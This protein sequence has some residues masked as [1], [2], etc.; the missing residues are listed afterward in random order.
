[1]RVPLK[2]LS[3]YV[4]LSLDADE[5][6]ELLTASGTSVEGVE[7]VG[8]EWKG[9]VV[10]RILEVLPHPSADRL[11]VCR[12]DVGGATR[13]IVCGAPN[14]RPGMV[15]PVAL[16][17]NRLPDGRSIGEA[18]IRGV[19]SSGM[20][21]SERELGISDEAAGIMEL[22]GALQP[23]TDLAEALEVEDTVLVLEI[24]P[25]RPDC[26]SMLGVAREVAA[27]TGRRVRRPRFDLP[28][29][30]EPAAS[31]VKVEILEADRCPRYVARLIEGVSI[32]P[33]PWWLRN[34]LRAAGM[35][36]INNVV[37]VTNY[38]MLEL[39]QPLHAFDFHLLRDGHIIVRCKREGERLTTLDGVERELHP[40]DLLI[41]DPGGPVALAGVMGGENTEVNPGTVKVLLESAHFSAPGIMLTSRRHDL[42]SEASYRF[43]RG[44][45]PAGCLFAADRA[46]FLIKETAGGRVRRG[47]VDVVVKPEVLLPRELRLRVGRAARLIGITL[48]APE[49]RGILQ[50]LE[51]EVSTA[52][53]GG[54]S[55]AG[56][57]GEGVPPPP[58]VAGGEGDGE[59]L[60]VKV[61][62]FRPDLER[63]IDLVEELARVYGYQRV[64]ATLPRT[65]NNVGFLTREQVL[66][67]EIA[68]VMVGC[69]LHEA[70]TWA[71]IPFWWMDLLDPE[72]KRL[73][74]RPLRLRNPLSEE[75]SVMRPTL[76]PGLLE[77]ARFNIN[78]RIPDVHLFEMGRVFLP[79]REGDLPH[80]PL[81]LGCLVCGRWVPKGWDQEAVEADFFVLKGILE[82]LSRALH[83]EDWSLR[84]EEYP[85]LHPARSAEVLLNGE[86]AGFLG[87]LHPR[88]AE[89][90][91]LPVGVEI[92]ELD[93]STLVKAAREVP[94]YREIPRFPAVQV[95]LAVVVREEVEA[96]EVEGI[97]REVGGEL[98]REVRL[99]DLY[100]GGQL[101]EGEKSLAYNLVFY[102]LDRT[103]RDEEVRR[104]VEGI[105]RALGEKLGARLR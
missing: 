9:C 104:S 82:A 40:E 55:P 84:R 48:S 16:P 17:G 23:G 79:V 45:D 100:R 65:S 21:L 86:E 31:E 103:L 91:D 93:V 67:R 27:L 3:E 94:P 39:G 38:V 83:V 62:T 98:L 85:F 89:A 54:E 42:S 7:K 25:N 34:R 75:A 12:V 95:D 105:V 96:R 1:M 35:R 71:F 47:A 76:I 88:V 97:I 22:D 6:A 33:S 49:A 30:G 73:P 29:E 57:A 19:V 50:S 68:R 64:P 32:G 99:F 81:L 92:M 43:E 11:S 70:I 77:A 52:E 15:S 87:T 61:P 18:E 41:C 46:A 37:D 69:G 36:P 66:R 24:T 90:L 44:V 5:L 8:G 58:V 28:E 4:E 56:V 26:L 101:A 14:V 13:D 63:E 80:E 10:G 2:W 60:R 74:E 72:R 53:M 51:M 59:V 102:A 20:L 78:R